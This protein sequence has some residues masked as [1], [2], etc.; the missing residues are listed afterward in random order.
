MPSNGVKGRN[1]K[2][3]GI[4]FRNMALQRTHYLLTFFTV[5]LTLTFGIMS[6]SLYKGVPPSI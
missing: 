4:F 6:P 2:T 5:L 3:G 1:L